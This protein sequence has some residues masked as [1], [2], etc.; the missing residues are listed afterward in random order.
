MHFTGSSSLISITVTQHQEAQS[1]GT[2]ACR[3]S[4][5]RKWLSFLDL[6]RAF[7]IAWV[8]THHTVSQSKGKARTRRMTTSSQWTWMC[9]QVLNFLL[10]GEKWEMSDLSGLITWQKDKV[11]RIWF[12]TVVRGVCEG[13]GRARAG[14]RSLLLLGLKR[15]FL[16]A[17]V[18]TLKRTGAD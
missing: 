10:Y 5:I 14:K 7:I 8:V 18:M 6:I 12:F 17:N 2:A 16:S 4:V 9:R 15:M 13:I 1:G 3:H 11:V